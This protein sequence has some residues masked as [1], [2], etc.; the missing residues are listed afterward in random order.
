MDQCQLCFRWIMDFRT[1]YVLD[2]EHVFHSLC[3]FE[4]FDHHS[5][6]CPICRSRLSRIDQEF[7]NMV[8]NGQI[9]LP[10]DGDLNDSGYES[11]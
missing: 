11:C 3:L 6:R 9:F 2:C 7:F 1:Y 5:Y 10:E 8:F 4:F